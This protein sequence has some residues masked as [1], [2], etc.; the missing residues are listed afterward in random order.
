VIFLTRRTNEALP[1]NNIRNRRE[2]PVTALSLSSSAD[3]LLQEALDA[4][5]RLISRL[6]LELQLARAR[7]SN[8]A[9]LSSRLSPE[10]ESLSD[11]YCRANQNYR[12]QMMQSL[13]QV[14]RAGRRGQG[15]SDL[16]NKVN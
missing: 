10:L 14:S 8:G 15:S 9:D 16:R 12:R 4:G 6:R 7:S 2:I 1:P 13:Q 3:T 5:D 11:A